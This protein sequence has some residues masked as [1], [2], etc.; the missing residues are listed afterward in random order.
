MG[1]VGRAG[2]RFASV[3]YFLKRQAC[4][5]RR[6]LG[7]RR[8]RPHDRSSKGRPVP[9]LAPHATGT[10]RL[11]SPGS[12]ADLPAPVMGEFLPRLLGAGV[13]WISRCFHTNRL[14]FYPCGR[15]WRAA[16]DEGYAISSPPPLRRIE[17]PHPDF[18]LDA[19]NLSLSHKG[20]GV[21]GGSPHAR[22]SL[23]PL[24]EKVPEGRMRSL[25]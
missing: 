14:P 8:M 17:T 2:G 23:L 1:E 12:H 20:R 15:R 19:E 13:R 24:W 25:R 18:L 11:T 9:E 10:L 7:Q 21:A 22:N 5:R 6:F 3:F 4:L 16:P